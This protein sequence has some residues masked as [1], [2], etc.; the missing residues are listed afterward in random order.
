MRILI[1]SDVHANLLALDAVL[2]HAGEYDR[3]WCLGDIVGYGPDPNEC[4]DRIAGLPGLICV[5]GNHDAAILGEIDVKTFNEE[6]RNSIYWLE[7]R[8]GP[9]QKQ[10]LANLPERLVLDGVTLVHGSPRNPVWEYILDLS[11]ARANMK[12]FDTQVC[13]VGHTHVA[14]IFQMSGEH[15]LVPR[16]FFMVENEPFS[17]EKKC[18]VNPGSVGQPRDRDPRAAYMVYDDESLKWSYHRVAYDITQV[19]ERILSAGLPRFHA[20]RLTGGW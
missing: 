6:A 11:T 4:I 7:S 10:W 14:G 3:A 16:H 8:L 19:Q 12:H 2:E 13:L 18:I 9:F 17:L 1:I 15:S 5:K 20:N